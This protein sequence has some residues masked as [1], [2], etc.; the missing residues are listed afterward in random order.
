MTT[1]TRER[2]PPIVENMGFKCFYLLT[3]E[4][5]DNTLYFGYMDNIFLEIVSII[6]DINRQIVRVMMG[7]TRRYILID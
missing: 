6:I 5:L 3:S 2:L 7:I 4:I 1:T